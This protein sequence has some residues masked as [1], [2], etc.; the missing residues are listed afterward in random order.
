MSTS[1]ILNDYEAVLAYC[2]DKTMNSYE[3]ALPYGRLSGYFDKNNK[4]TTMGQKVA[5]LLED[6]LAA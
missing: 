6:D 5:R 2:G 3:Q 1:K 4:L